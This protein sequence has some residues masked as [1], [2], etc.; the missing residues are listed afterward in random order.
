MAGVDDAHTTV[1]RLRFTVGVNHFKRLLLGELHVAGRAQSS[2]VFEAIES[3]GLRDAPPMETSRP[4][5]D[6]VRWTG[7][8]LT[9]R[10]WENWFG[11]AVDLPKEGKLQVLDHAA[12]RVIRW[13]RPSDGASM[14]LPHGFY[15]S[16]ISGGLMTTLLAPTKAADVLAVLRN[17]AASYAPASAW[18]LHLDALEIRSH[19]QDFRGVS[20]HQLVEIAAVRVLELLYQLWRVPDGR[21]YQL[22]SSDLVLAWEGASAEERALM[23]RAFARQ[24]PDLFDRRLRA[25][26]EPSW[27]KCGVTRD[28]PPVQVHRLLF[29]LGADV[30]FARADRL[31]AW[32]L[33]LATAALAAHALAWTDRYRLL[34]RSVTEEMVY[35]AAL[36]ALLSSAAPL[37][38]GMS[39]EE[40]ERSYAEDIALE[41]DEAMACSGAD[42]AE[43]GIQ[44]LLAARAA[45]IA[46][47]T[48]LGTSMGE[49]QHLARQAQHYYPLV[50]GHALTATDH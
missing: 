46:E 25:G 13:R 50:Y 10:T 37:T 33:D 9:P 38:V 36:D 22:F 4:T 20:R 39:T 24:V 15:R 1:G 41:L 11:N 29:G 34:G 14:A 17:R 27:V 12:A 18:H 6:P 23:R 2:A 26:A 40:A 19:L 28:I 48:E 31:A 43:A 8:R 32:S 7:M 5:F 49:L 45:Y 21:I 42:W 35:L 30:D 16:L 3:I 47:L 44:L